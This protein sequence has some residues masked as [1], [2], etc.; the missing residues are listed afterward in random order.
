MYGVRMM[1]RRFTLVLCTLLGACGGSSGPV[2]DATYFW[3]LTSSAV[4]FGACSDDADFRA[5]LPPI[6]LSENTFLVYRVAKDGRTAVSQDCTQLDARTCA[7]DA[8]GPVFDIAGRELTFTRQLKQ[9][10]GTTGCSLQQTETQ[11]LTDNTRTMT[12]ELQ[13]VLTLVDAPAACGRVEADQK[14]RSPNG[15]GVEGCVVTFKLTGALR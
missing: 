3:Q 8:E 7:P 10:I 12:L 11:V 6:E 9:P 15:L 1:Q 2:P 5:G 14:A 4:E 13:N